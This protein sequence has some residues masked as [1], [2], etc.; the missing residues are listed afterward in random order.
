MNTVFN[1]VGDS[2]PLIFEVIAAKIFAIDSYSEII[3]PAVPA[4]FKSEQVVGLIEP[5]QKLSDRYNLLCAPIYIICLYLDVFASTSLGRTSIMTHEIDIGSAIPINQA[6]FR[7]FQVH[8]ER[9]ILKICWDREQLN[10]P[11]V[12][13]APPWFLIRKKMVALVLIMEGLM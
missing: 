12:H 2:S 7:V 5:V 1:T 8:K 9:N 4:T 6:P 10:S 13:G 11:L 3:I